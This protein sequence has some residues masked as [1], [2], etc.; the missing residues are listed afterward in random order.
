MA[1]DRPAQA[2]AIDEIADRRH[3]ELRQ[4]HRTKEGLD[5][6][7]DVLPIG[8]ERCAFE[9]VGAARYQPKLRGLYDGDALGIS[10]MGAAAN[11]DAGF[12]VIGIGVPLAG[13]GLDMPIACLIDIVDDPGLPQLAFGGFPNSFAN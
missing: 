8:V 11:L 6:Q 13:K 1:A 5:M 3:R 12:G 9:V 2:Q 10:G 7:V 4:P